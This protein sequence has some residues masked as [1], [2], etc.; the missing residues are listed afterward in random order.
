MY[1]CILTK[2]D[3]CRIFCYFRMSFAIVTEI[4]TDINNFDTLTISIKN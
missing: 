4:F 1:T 3:N 2:Y